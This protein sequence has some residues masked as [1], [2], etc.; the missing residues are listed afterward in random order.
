MA[1]NKK[2]LYCLIDTETT[3]HNGLVFDMAYELM[4]KN[5]Q[6]YELESFLFKDVLAI[7]DPFY[8]EKIAEY[9]NLCYKQKVKPLSTKAVRRIFNKQMASYQN[10]GYEIVM[11]A[12]NA[13]FD[14]RVLGETSRDKIG[15]AW[16]E[17]DVA[18]KGI[19][20]FDLWHGWV[21]GCPKNYGVTAAMS[22]KGNIKTSA[23]EVFRYISHNPQFEEK[24]V[25]HSDIKIEK[26]I[27]MDILKRKKKLHI[28][29]SPKSF[30]AQPWK[31][32]QE[33]CRAAIEYRKAK[34]SSLTAVIDKIASQTVS[35]DHLRKM[36]IVDRDNIAESR[37]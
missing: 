6:T 27:L 29:D 18:T 12:F 24:H 23:E 36:N 28:V 2:R 10:K 1:T 16:L 32:A 31:I 30:V 8:K 34:Q 20:L 14:I 5:G 9:W 33:R 4:D 17:K 25:A 26:I 15:K 13:A 22:E 3:K 11:T 21:M 37:D 19:K 7:E 35:T